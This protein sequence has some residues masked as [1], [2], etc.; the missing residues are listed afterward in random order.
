MHIRLGGEE[1]EMAAYIFI[2]IFILFK[3]G[4]TLCYYREQTG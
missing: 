2:F 4:K 1:V 3:K